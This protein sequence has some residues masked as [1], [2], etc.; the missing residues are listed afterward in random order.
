LACFAGDIIGKDLEAGR[1]QSGYKGKKISARRK[2]F[3]I[4]FISTHGVSPNNNKSRHKKLWM[5]IPSIRVFI[6]EIIFILL[7]FIKLVMR[8]LKQITH[9]AIGG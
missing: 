2:E 7:R 5:E 3:E 6:Y 4:N 1:W 9:R 8:K